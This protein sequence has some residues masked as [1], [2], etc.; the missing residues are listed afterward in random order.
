[1]ENPK[2]NVKA[3]L[4]LYNGAAAW[5]FLTIPKKLSKDLDRLFSGIKGGFG[6]IP[7]VATIGS[8]IFRTSI[9]KDTKIGSY[10]LPIKKE[11]RKK[12]LIKIGDTVKFTLEIR[13]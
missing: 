12:E 8:T 11:V 4:W 13:V 3:K 10:L 6:S 2:F 9:F 5:H 1:M 7:V